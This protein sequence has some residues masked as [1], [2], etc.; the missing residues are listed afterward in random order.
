MVL[1]EYHKMLDEIYVR[2]FNFQIETEQYWE[3]VRIMDIMSGW[4]TNRNVVS[5]DEI[6]NYYKLFFSDLS[7]EEYGIGEEA[8][9]DLM[10]ES[11]IRV[12]NL[13]Q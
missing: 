9:E 11:Y 12:E 5:F 10:V 6:R 7:G 13:L 3:T 8:H 4:I 1:R 2:R